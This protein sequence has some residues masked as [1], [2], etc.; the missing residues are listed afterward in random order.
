MSSQTAADKRR[1]V[2]VI[3]DNPDIQEALGDAFLHAGIAAVFA[4]DGHEALA[5]LR[6]HDPPGLILLDLMMPR[7]DGM[8]F[9]A[10]QLRDPALADIPV[11]LLSADGKLDERVKAM[12]PAGY[13]AKPVQLV[14]LLE[15]VTR[16]CEPM[17]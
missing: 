10:E 9:R 8:Q 17:Y 7:M 4:A 3:E 13:L 6:S 1:P 12:S 16:Y 14:D 5:Y 11:V 15:M 2:M